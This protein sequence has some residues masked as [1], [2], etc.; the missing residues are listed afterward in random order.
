MNLDSNR[1]SIYMVE[2]TIK[3]IATV[4][5]PERICYTIIAKANRR[6]S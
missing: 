6:W 4:T 3:R 5:I 1:L 2:A